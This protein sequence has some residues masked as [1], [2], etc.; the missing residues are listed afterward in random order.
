MGVD[1][2]RLLKFYILL[3]ARNSKK[4]ATRVRANEVTR[5]RRAMQGKTAITSKSGVPRNALGEIGNKNGRQ[6]LERE[7]KKLGAGLKKAATVSEVPSVQVMDTDQNVK[8]EVK[9]DTQPVF[10]LGVL[11]IDA[12]PEDRLNPQLCVE[13]APAI[14]AYLRGVEEGLSIRKE[15][16]QGMNVSGK[17]RAVL[18]DWLIEVH[19]QFKLLQETLYM[20]V[21]VI[22]KFLQ[23]E[24]YSIKRNKLQLVGVTAMFLASK[25]EEMYAPEINDFVYITDNA[26]SAAEIRQMELKILNTLNFNMSRPLPLHF[27]RRNSK[28]GDVDVLQHTV[29]KYLVELS[30]LEYDLAH[31]P[32]SLMAA[33]SLYLSLRILEPNAT[34]ANVWTPTLQYYSTYTTR[35]L[36][37]VVVKVAQA[38]LKSKDS[39]LQAVHTKYM[40]KKF[41]KVGELADLH[42][43]VMIKLSK[44]DLEGL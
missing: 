20:T 28:A 27:L 32:P 37:P 38:I 14:Y 18:I 5:G 44:K 19:S 42:G 11:D 9:K 39:K 17:M 34:L 24:G 4:M 31:Y 23:T 40:S 21:Y 16:L 22:D 2:K 26:Y 13:Y 36:L 33:A 8:E 41:M 35:D 1:T 30:L 6:E 10:P 3:L 12:V 15:F 25:V 29:A 43:D 7:G